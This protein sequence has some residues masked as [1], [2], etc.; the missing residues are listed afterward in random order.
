MELK[1]WSHISLGSLLGSAARLVHR[2]SNNSPS[3]EKRS[4]M[5]EQNQK[6]TKK[7]TTSKQDMSK[8]RTVW[9]SQSSSK[10]KPIITNSYQVAKLTLYI[11]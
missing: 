7:K 4:A 2:A 9:N 10:T 5:T 8:I 6:K 3:H 1:F 11:V